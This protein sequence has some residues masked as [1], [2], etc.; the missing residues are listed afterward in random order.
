MKKNKYD[1]GLDELLDLLKKNPKLMKE[2]V[3]EPNNCAQL[4]ARLNSR[5][6][7]EMVGKPVKKFLGY[8]AGNRD[9]YPIAQCFEGTQALCA[10]GTRCG[11]CGG[12][13][14]PTEILQRRPLCRT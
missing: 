10:K 12:M 1:K 2:L 6:A 11:L 3:F 9:G 5:G 14:E 7:R 4:L 13:T 8:V